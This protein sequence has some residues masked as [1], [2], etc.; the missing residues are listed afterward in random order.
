MDTTVQVT[1]EDIIMH[2]IDT[3]VSHY[4]DALARI[5]DKECVVDTFQLG[6]IY[7]V[8]LRAGRIFKTLNFNLQEL[9]EEAN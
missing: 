8:V 2:E 9:N 6:I 5:T 4:Q 3:L 1:K 7:V